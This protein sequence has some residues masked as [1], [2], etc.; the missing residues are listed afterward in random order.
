MR[1]D[2]SHVQMRPEGVPEQ[3][4]PYYDPLGAVKLHI[5]QRV[6]YF[7]YFAE[8]FLAPPG[9]MAYGDEVE[10]LAAS[11]ADTTLGDLQSMVVD[12]EVFLSNFQKYRNIHQA[13]IVI[14]NLTILTGD[15]DDPRFDEFYL[16]G[17]E[18][19]LFMGLFLADWPSYQ[20]LGFEQRDPHPKPA[21]NEHYTKLYVFHLEEGPKATHGPYQWGKNGMLFQRLLQIRQLADE[22]LP[23]IAHTST[24]WLLTPDVDAAI[25]VAAWTQADDPHYLFVVNLSGSKTAEELTIPLPARKQ[26]QLVF[27]SLEETVIEES[28]NK[29]SLFEPDS[30]RVRGSDNYRIQKSG[31]LQ[32]LEDGCVIGLEAGECRCYKIL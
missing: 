27:S 2:M 30:Y 18:A 19:R 8:S 11:Q 9:V 15:K 3:A 17:N 14:P 29:S 6:P 21:P 24:K 4:D 23:K 25:P 22:L 5:Q 26:I 13:G 32:T 31:R 12:S 16:Y 10:H 28:L 20:G 7:A 1:G